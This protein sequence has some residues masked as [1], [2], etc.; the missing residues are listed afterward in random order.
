MTQTLMSGSKGMAKL[1]S[2]LALASSASAALPSCATEAPSPEAGTVGTS[3]EGLQCGKLGTQ[4]PSDSGT[5]GTWSCSVTGFCQFKADLTA[6]DGCVGN[7]DRGTCVPVGDGRTTPQYLMCCTGCYTGKLGI[8]A[9]CH[10]GNA[11]GYCG[12]GGER[13]DVCNDCQTCT[14]NSCVATSGNAC[15]TCQVC[16]AGS[17]DPRA[18]GAVCSGGHCAAGNTCCTEN[19]CIKGTSCVASA[20][21]NCGSNGNTC[22]DCGQCGTCSGGECADREGSCDDGDPCTEN[23]TCSNGTCAGTEIDVDDGNPCTIDACSAESGV[24]HTSLD[25]G[26]ACPDDGSVCTSGERCTDEDGDDET[27]RVCL[28]E[29]G[30]TCFDDNPC[31]SDAVDCDTNTCPYAP[32]ANDEPCSSNNRCIIEESCQDGTCTG[33]DRNCN[34]DNPCTTDSCEPDVTDPDADPATGCKHVPRTASCDDG[35]PCTEDDECSAGQCEGT[36]KECTALDECHGIG[37]CDP[38]TGQ[39]TDPQLQDGTGCENTGRCEEGRCMGGT[40]PATGGA[41]GTAGSSTG[42]NATGGTTSTGSA[43][44]AG[45]DGAAGERPATGGASGSAGRGGNA[46]RGGANGG[47]SS[48]KFGG[49]T[50]ARDPGG[51]SCEVP[52]QHPTSNSALGAIIGGALTL[53]CRRRRRAA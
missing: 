2:A 35:N 48:G 1:F 8:D 23:D 50:Y 49:T 16:N 31:T 17:C 4:C 38:G 12:A 28:P 44:E 39:C 51:C 18:V 29:T 41:G 26:E 52:R 6:G 5:C 30:T 22:V 53:L 10:P 32:V 9:A 11:V 3:K 21:A 25:E 20:D 40:S 14:N 46:G 19:A 13:C 36:P 27:P 47:G 33:E 43:G 24:T 37:T 7:G 34:D 42:G 45:E 15:G